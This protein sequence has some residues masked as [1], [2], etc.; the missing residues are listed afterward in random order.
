MQ[1]QQ[2]ETA[3]CRGPWEA[4][5]HLGPVEVKPEW[6][7]SHGEGVQRLDQGTEEQ[8]NQAPGA[9]TQT[10]QE[11]G[12]MQ[13]VREQGRREWCFVLS[14]SPFPFQTQQLIN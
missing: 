5:V 11:Q 3:L 14:P 4:G 2:E 9:G 6:G 12:K 8:L 7:M 1:G 13:A 10:F